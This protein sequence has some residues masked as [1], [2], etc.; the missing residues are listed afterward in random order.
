MKL[1]VLITETSYGSVRVD[2]PEG[3]TE[4]QIFDAAYSAYCEG[5]AYFGNADFD[6]TGWEEE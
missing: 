6:I 1:N 4:E 2:V 3:A 5:R